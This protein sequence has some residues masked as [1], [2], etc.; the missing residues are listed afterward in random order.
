MIK[1]VMNSMTLLIVLVLFSVIPGHAALQGAGKNAPS[2]FSYL[3]QP[4]FIVMLLIGLFAL[5]LLKTK[6]MKKNIKIP[7]LLLSTFLFGIAGNIGTKFFSAFAMH[8]S[9]VCASVKPFLFG[10]RIPFLVT[11][12]VIFLLTLI[13][14][15][16]FCS[17]ICPV[18]AVQELIAMWADKLKISRKKT[19]F[20]FSQTIRLAIFIFFIFFC[21]AG[22]LTLSQNGRTFSFNIYDYINAFHG[23]EFIIQATLLDNLFHFLPFL[24]TLIL[25]FKFYRPFCHY[26]CP[27]GLYTHFLEQIAIFRIKLKKPPCDDCGVCEKKAPCKAVPDILKGANLRPDCYGCNV[28]VEVCPKN[29]LSIGR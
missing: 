5:L 14:P 23:F 19:S 26:I 7:L 21:A 9:P 8:P 18:G 24:L 13:G 4:K 17:W 12:S 11:L 10:F 20:A 25:A 15:K 27:V 29:A 6:N 3:L 28:C 1:K 16:L 22:I 2:Y